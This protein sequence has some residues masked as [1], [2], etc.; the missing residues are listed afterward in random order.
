MPTSIVSLRTNLKSLK[1][2]KDRTD[3]GDSNQPYITTPIPDS[4]A[5][6][7]NGGE[8]E[9]FLLRGGIG[10]P[11]DAL[12]DVVRLGKYFTDFKNINGLLFI[13]KQN[14]LSRVSPATQASGNQSTNNKWKG[15]ALNEGVYTPLSTLAQAGINFLGGHVDKQG[16]NPF[17]GVTTYSD[18]HEKVIG[19]PGTGEG[20]RL[21]DLTN[22][23]KG[24]FSGP[25]I[26]S[27]SGG[28]NSIVG[29]GKTRINFAT[30][31]TGAVIK[32]LSNESFT[33]SF[34]K[35]Q[36]GAQN[37]DTDRDNL[38]EEFRQ[39]LGV[40]EKYA[41]I[42]N[43]KINFDGFGGDIY[44]TEGGGYTGQL[45]AVSKV[46]GVWAPLANSEESTGETFNLALGKVITPS[47][48]N[49]TQNPT[50]KFKN[51][52]GVSYI[53]SK[54]VGGDSF[55]SAGNVDVF[56]N[57]GI[58]LAS[59]ESQGNST[60]YGWSH[61]DST[62]VYKT[63]DDKTPFLTP[64]TNLKSYQV[65]LRNNPTDLFVYPEPE[66]LKDAS[67]LYGFI[68]QDYFDV[69]TVTGDDGISLQQNLT[70]PYATGVK[71]TLATKTYIKRNFLKTP[72]PTNLFQVPTGSTDYTKLGL[73]GLVSS[74]IDKSNGITWGPSN[75]TP[76][77]YITGSLVNNNRIEDQGTNVYTQELIN[78]QNISTTNKNNPGSG[79]QD[80]QVEL[81]KGKKD[82]TIMSVSPDY[83]DA[84]NKSIEGPTDSRINYVSPGQ[85]GN[86]YSYT[87]GKFV[88]GSKTP[89]ITDRI[90]A[91]PLYKS[92]NVA[93]T[94]EG[95]AGGFKNDLV[96]FRIA[97]V[98]TNDPSKKVYMHFRAYI[99]S[100]DDQYSANWNAQK[101]M[102]RGENFYKYDSFDRN[103]NLSF[104][105]AAQSKPEIMVMYRKLNYLASNLAPDYTNAGF[106][107]GPLV[108]LT[109][110]AWC[111]ELPGF[112]SA[113]TLS[114]P[115][116]SP[117]E[118]ALNDE[119]NFDG[120]VKEMPHIVKVTGFSFK[121]IHTFRPA[122]MDLKNPMTS[123][124][125]NL[126][127]NNTYG[128][129]RYLALKSNN[130]NYSDKVNWYTK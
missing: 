20:N 21:V 16:L 45:A 68:S 88:N 22:S 114:V 121:P 44:A 42:T 7:K 24:I 57:K 41:T 77:V 4:D 67:G 73:K 69:G 61:Q 86:K 49:R 54:L 125:P 59:I 8:F 56:T 97:S 94:E 115:Q 48:Y 60:Q 112:I 39:P 5:P 89:S 31:N 100:F 116:E 34:I 28:P 53:Y 6:R 18:V 38:K 13:A 15:A 95:N 120:T 50:D 84:K 91:L 75:F 52:L 11:I 43:G 119:G 128:D 93:A 51:P 3:G 80:F 23:N 32:V 127:D 122:K 40:S 29:I 105:V 83:T 108:Q 76:G 47:I 30:N 19:S 102:G 1:Y 58:G 117:W 101:Y 123:P 36:T 104:T 130:N 78:T 71:G 85:K 124:Q 129:E 109:L 17:K 12:T 46:T 64:I 81:L 14:L 87:K 63:K 74:S 96:K 126:A 9:D 79:I 70:N 35:N 103:V 82:S 33:D 65:G 111:Y 92:S 2:G 90:N 106:M 25:E 55:E 99:D 110:G 113:L 66:D 118:I 107:S 27:Y 37:S 10:A 26:F 62:S 98:D 72:N